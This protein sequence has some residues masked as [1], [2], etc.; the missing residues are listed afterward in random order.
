MALVRP[1]R[2]IR[3]NRQFAEKVVSLPYD[4]MNREEAE[5]MVKDNPYSFLHISRSEIDLPEQK[6]PYAPDVYEK[7]KENLQQFLD[8]KIFIEEAKPMF[9]IY[10][11]QMRDKIQT[12]LVGCVSVDDYFNDII[13]KHEHTREEKEL[14]RT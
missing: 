8:K 11:Q 2:A 5:A 3:P 1:F 14:D 10:R 4:V 12:G 7:A 6:D 9:Y 13:K